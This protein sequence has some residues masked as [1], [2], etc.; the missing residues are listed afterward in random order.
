[1]AN[2]TPQHVANYFLKRADEENRPI[3][4]LKLIKLVYIAHGWNLALLG[5]P[6]FD[7]PVQAW[8]YGPVVPSVYHEFK[9]FG[10]RSI[11]QM[12]EN[13][14]LDTMAAECPQIPKSDAQT[15]KI[16]N[17]VWN[18]YRKFSGEALIEKTHEEGS[19]WSETFEP[20]VRYSVIDDDLIRQ[21]FEERISAYV[22]YG[23]RSKKGS[24]GKAA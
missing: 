10:R 1:M 6:L 13:L 24:R 15:H 18:A 21:H 23:R 2:Y 12:A 22:E 9:H 3:T 8:R 20:G 19:P 4:Q 17:L 7:E 14:D 5:E 16:L 11:D